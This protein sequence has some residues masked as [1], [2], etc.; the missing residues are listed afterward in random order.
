M[1]NISNGKLTK[2]QWTMVKDI[3]KSTEPY[4]VDS[5]EFHGEEVETTLFEDAV[6]TAETGW[7]ISYMNTRA[8]LK[9]DDLPA[10]N[11]VLDQEE[12]GL[13]FLRY[14]FARYRLSQLIDIYRARAAEG[15]PPRGSQFGKDVLLWSSIARY[16]RNQIA[17]MNLALVLKIATKVSRGNSATQAD[18]FVAIGNAKLLDAVDKFD[19]S[20]GNKFSTYA[21]HAVY[22]A[23]IHNMRKETLEKIRT[24]HS[25]DVDAE[26][27]GISLRDSL[28]EEPVDDVATKENK[29]MLA[30]VLNG[31][32]ARLSKRENFII[33]M[34][35]L[36]SRP[37]GRRYIF[38]EVGEMV[39]LS[40]TGV[41]LAERAALQKLRNA[42]SKL[43]KPVK[44]R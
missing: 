22:R 23:L 20:T 14:N 8:K 25:Y 6:P 2:E 35:F 21:W 42:W 43:S 17:S 15:R 19:V 1:L 40:R 27:D 30:E 39:G 38:E 41:Q 34:R 10:A 29:Q 7:Y 16:L 28:A 33:R 37:D 36:E 24:P 44:Q 18:D 3:I 11:V 12:E 32:L 31:N 13:M 5:E 26:D 9:H 4:Y